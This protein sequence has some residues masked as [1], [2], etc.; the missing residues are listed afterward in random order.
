MKFR[1]QKDAIIKNVLELFVGIRKSCYD[2]KVESTSVN[3]ECRTTYMLIIKR[4]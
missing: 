1:L 4:G 3:I 2:R